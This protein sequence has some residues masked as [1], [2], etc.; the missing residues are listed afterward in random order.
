MII[1]LNVLRGFYSLDLVFDFIVI[2][3]DVI[4]RIVLILN[5]SWKL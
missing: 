2:N 4:C 5:L 3:L 1:D